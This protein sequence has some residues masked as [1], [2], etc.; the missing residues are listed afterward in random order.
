[1]TH[2]W[3]FTNRT[4]GT[5]LESDN[6]SFLLYQLTELRGFK[7][8]AGYG[9]MLLSRGSENAIALTA[10]GVRNTIEIRKVPVSTGNVVA[11]ARKTS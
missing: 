3:R 2:V 1:M 8:P 11:F 6:L 4:T 7:F 10:E 9:I 5:R